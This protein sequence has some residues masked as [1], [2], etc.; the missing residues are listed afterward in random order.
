MRFFRECLADWLAHVQVSTFRE[1]AAKCAHIWNSD[2]YSHR[3]LDQRKP[4]PQPQPDTDGCT[5]SLQKTFR[6]TI[7]PSWNSNV[8]PSGLASPSSYRL[9]TRLIT[10]G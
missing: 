5:T 1:R 7:F 4:V 6:P 10:T 3:P 9:S 2:L 8:A